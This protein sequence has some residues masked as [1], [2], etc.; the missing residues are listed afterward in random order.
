MLT[1][2]LEPDLRLTICG[3]RRTRRP[4]RG[5]GHARAFHSR[6][7]LPGARGIRGLRSAPP[8][9]P[10]LSRHHRPMAGLAG[11]A[12]A[13]MS[14]RW[15]SFGQELDGLATPRHLL[16]HCHAGISRSTAAMATLLARHT[17]VG[18]EDGIFQRIREIRPI[19][20]PNSRMIGFADDIL[21]R[22]GRLNA[23]ACANTTGVAGAPPPGV[24]GRASRN[25]RGA[26]IPEVSRPDV[27]AVMNWSAT[28]AVSGGRSRCHEAIRTTTAR[29]LP[30]RH[31]SPRT[32][33]CRFPPVPALGA[34]R[35]GRGAAAGRA[36]ARPRQGG[37]SGPC[38]GRTLVPDRCR[39]GR[40]TR[41]A[42]PGRVL[43]DRRGCRAGP[44]A[45]PRA[46][47]GARPS[48][49]A[50]VRRASWACSTRPATGSPATS[51]GRCTGTVW[52][53]CR[54]CRR[55]WRGWP[56]C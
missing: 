30:G 43:S 31:S 27:P 45:R 35:L 16:V 3:H 4:P 1:T 33:P 39:P 11:A 37:P 46:G 52:R 19:A 12:S 26:E 36:D 44:G 17:P 7:G 14:R 47:S 50:R 18:E 54:A 21:G 22:G 2:L 8:A 53:R 42:Q 24:H 34:G 29:R 5:P 20:W 38:P 32:A 49:G 48:R 15:S 23:S 28:T 6:S 13:S 10:A 9:D 51:A 41:P 25:G 40:R 55:P 56:S